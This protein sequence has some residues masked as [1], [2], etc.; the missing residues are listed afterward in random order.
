MK[1]GHDTTPIRG[2]KPVFNMGEGRPQSRFR[3]S[4][5]TPARLRPRREQA[6]TPNTN[7]R[8]KFNIRTTAGIVQGV[9]HRHLRP[10]QRGDGWA[11]TH[12]PEQSHE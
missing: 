2:G 6:V 11:Y 7:R 12:Q 10:L 4:G 8:S 5:V 1:Q 3:D 9:H